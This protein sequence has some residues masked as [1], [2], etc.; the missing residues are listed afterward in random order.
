LIAEAAV[1]HQ[2]TPDKHTFRAFQLTFFNGKPG[3]KIVL[4]RLGDAD[5]TLYN[6]SKDMLCLTDQEHEDR[7]SMFVSLSLYRSPLV[8]LALLTIGHKESGPDSRTAVA[9]VSA[10]AMST[11]IAINSTIIAIILLVGPVV[12][13]YSVQLQKTR[14]ILIAVFTTVFAVGVG[15]LTNAKRTEVYGATAA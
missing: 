12:A 13:L 2:P 11:F 1:A 8:P 9:Y 6:E 14:L 4:R 7:L 10:R 3:S 5:R 15:P